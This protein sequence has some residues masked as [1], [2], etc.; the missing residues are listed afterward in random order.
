[1]TLTVKNRPFGSYATVSFVSNNNRTQITGM[2]T[3][4]LALIPDP[5]ADPGKAAAYA[6]DFDLMPPATADK[7]RA[8]L[9][10]LKLSVQGGLTNTS[11]L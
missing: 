9:T 6:P 2:I 8:E 1:M 4:L 7:L 11:D 3:S 5:S 10:A